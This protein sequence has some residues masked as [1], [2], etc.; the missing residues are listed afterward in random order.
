MSILI[1][2]VRKEQTSLIITFIYSCIVHMLTRLYLS[3]IV[4]FVNRIV[5]SR[6]ACHEYVSGN[7]V[8]RVALNISYEWPKEEV[9]KGEELE[10]VTI[11]LC[12]SV[13]AKQ[14]Q[15]KM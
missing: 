3:L 6:F 15:K 11:N 10:C 12:H 5:A 7:V 4:R 13:V 1:I 2:D 9:I 8:A 14:R